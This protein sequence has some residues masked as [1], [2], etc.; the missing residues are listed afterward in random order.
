[1]SLRCTSCL[2]YLCHIANFYLL[3]PSI[4]LSDLVI[5]IISLPLGKAF[6]C[7][8]KYRIL[9][10]DINPGPFTVKEHVVITMMANVA[11][12][13]AYATDIFATQ[14]IFYGQTIGYLYQILLALGT[15]LFGFALGAI[16][17]QIVVW[18]RSMIWPSALVYCALFNTMHKGYGKRERGHMPRERYF[19]IVCVGAFVW[20][21]IPGYLFTALSVFN[22]VCWIV[23]ENVTVNSLFGTYSGLGMSALTFDWSMIAYNGSPLATPV[24]LLFFLLLYSL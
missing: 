23:P 24:R 18:P 22:W 16:L 14:Q 2:V 3:D 17:R 1:M 9:G 13:G 7:L 12:Q 5:L 4:F 8:P 21:F 11:S 6:A 20:Y 10:C 15:Q 19:L